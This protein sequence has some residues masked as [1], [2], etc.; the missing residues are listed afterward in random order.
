MAHKKKETAGQLSD[1]MR[2]ET[3]Q[4]WVPKAGEKP[5]ERDKRLQLKRS[6]GGKDVT[7]K[8]QAERELLAREFLDKQ[9][10][11]SEERTRLFKESG[12]RKVREELGLEARDP[13]ELPS[14]LPEQQNPPQEAMS[15]PA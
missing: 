14:Q 6:I 12:A 1:R 5:E 15:I 2:R 9:A 8:P 7:D 11:A 3:A 13:S 10:G 4:G